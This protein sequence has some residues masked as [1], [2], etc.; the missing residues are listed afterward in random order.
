MRTCSVD[1]CNYSVFGTDKKT[2]KGY[3]KF[4]QSKRTDKKA[5]VRTFKPI[6]KRSKKTPFHKI[7]WGF[8]SQVDL[9]QKLWNSSAK[10]VCPYTGEILDYIPMDR[11]ICCFAHVLPKGRYPLFK[12]NPE[13]IRIVFP[14][15]HHAVDQGTS[16]DRKKHP[17]WRF[18]LWNQDVQ[19]MKEKYQ[20]FKNENLL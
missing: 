17:D 5:T 10:H 18:D 19:T 12:L 20:E 3:C 7:G 6:A 2:G 15:F 13:N 11:R 4:H 16:E 1:N 14:D 8:I 9:F